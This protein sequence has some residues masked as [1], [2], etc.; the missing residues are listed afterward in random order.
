MEESNV[1]LQMS[2]IS[3]EF[4]GVKA[5]SEVDFEVR[6]GEVMGLLG[7]NGA[8]KSTLIKIITGYYRKDGGSFLF[9]GK[10]INLSLIHI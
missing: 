5:L 3:K 7:E 1:L 8:G 6:R 10:E 9:D 4:P 2:K